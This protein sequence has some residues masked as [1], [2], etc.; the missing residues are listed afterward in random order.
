[1]YSAMEIFNIRKSSDAAYMIN[2]QNKKASGAVLAAVAKIIRSTEYNRTLC[3]Y[4]HYNLMQQ[5][6][7]EYN[8]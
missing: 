5:P 3:L 7:T 4:N 8:S 2:L 1:M 6:R